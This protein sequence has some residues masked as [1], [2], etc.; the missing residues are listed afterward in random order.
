MGVSQPAQER[1]RRPWGSWATN[2]RSLVRINRAKA[3]VSCARASATASSSRSRRERAIRW[4]IT[5][6]SVVVWK[7]EPSRS[8]SSLR[9]PRVHQVAVGRQGQGPEGIVENQGLGVEEAA[10]PGG[11]VADVADGGV[12][13]QPCAAR[14][15]QTL[16]SPAPCRGGAGMPPRRWRRCRRSPAPGAAA[17]A[18]RNR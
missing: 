10:L 4:A 12:P 16:P 9:R 13:R 7:M 8:S 14:R 15:H 17:R 3:P 11:G 18:G 6:V 1:G 2:S 5:S